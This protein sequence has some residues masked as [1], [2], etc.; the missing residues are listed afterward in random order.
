MYCQ[1]QKPEVNSFN[2]TILVNNG[3]GRSLQSPALFLVSADDSLFNFQTY[4]RK[5]FT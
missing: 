5:N 1:L 2:A 3:Y 4:A